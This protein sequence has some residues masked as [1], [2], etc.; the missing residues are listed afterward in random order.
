MERID[1][2]DD[3]SLD[4]RHWADVGGQPSRLLPAIDG[5]A[6]WVQQEAQRRL[7]RVD[8]RERTDPRD[9]SFPNPV[10]KILTSNQDVVIVGTSAG[11]IFQVGADSAQI[12]GRPD[13]VEGAPGSLVARGETTVLVFTENGAIYEVSV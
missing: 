8:A 4:L 11:E 5:D 3:L 13:L 12:L 7:T 1:V 2:A 6:V 9:V 10:A